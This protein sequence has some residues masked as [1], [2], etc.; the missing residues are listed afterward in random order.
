[1]GRILATT[2]AALTL[3]TNVFGCDALLPDHV[4]IPDCRL[5]TTQ[6]NTAA[7]Q[8][9]I[10][11]EVL[12]R[13]ERSEGRVFVTATDLSG[14][15]T[16]LHLTET[17]VQD[18]RDRL[19]SAPQAGVMSRNGERLIAV[20]ADGRAVAELEGAAA[21]VSLGAT[22]DA[23]LL[24]P[25]ADIVLVH[26][27]PSSSGLSMDD[28]GQLAKPG[29]LAIVA[30]GD[31]GSVYAAAAGPRFPGDRFRDY[32]YAPA[33]AAAER[34]LRF[35]AAAGN[36]TDLRPFLPHV[37]SL[38]LAQV[39][40]IVYHATLGADCQVA[41]DRDRLSLGHITAAANHGLRVALTRP[42]G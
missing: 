17:G 24:Q 28:L 23:R 1:M 8:S 30:I 20:T 14:L 15:L 11:K 9:A 39:R 5:A 33:Q 26:N 38:A 12:K 3:G 18:W 27:H 16:A 13:V 37:I 22:L 7:G 4:R 35:N 32:V 6:A 21:Q 25:D 40:V 10:L 34:E 31:D 36:A 29:V 19:E 42:P 2:L 41:F